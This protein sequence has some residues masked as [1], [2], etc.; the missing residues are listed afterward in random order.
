MSS[1]SLDL[2]HYVRVKNNS[3]KDLKGRYDGVD[4]VFRV[5]Q[6]TDVHED[7]AKHIFGFGDEDKTRS[8]LRLGWLA[9]GATMDDALEKL[10]DFE[11][12]EVP[13]PSVDI[14]SAGRKAKTASKTSSPTLSAD[15]GA[16]DGGAVLAASPTDAESDAD[17]AE[18]F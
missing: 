12:G 8:F 15:A 1:G 11:F 7:V 13:N 10:N 6:V 5:N 3:T 2:S 9:N 4:Y 14:K 17:A 16:D 18:S